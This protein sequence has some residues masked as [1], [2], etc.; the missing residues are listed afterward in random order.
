MASGTRSLDLDVLQVKSLTVKTPQNRAIPS[1]HI[2]ISGGDG[3]TYWN[4]VSSIF[5]VSSF[6]TVVGN[7]GPRFSADLTYNT[8]KISTTGIQGLFE[9][10]I[11]PATSTMML[12]NSLPAS[13]VNLGSVPTVNLIQA[14][15]VPN[16]QQL[17][18]VTGLST[19][20]YF[21]VGD[22]QLSTINTQNAMFFSISSFTSAGYSTI[23]G[24]TFNLRPTIMSTLSTFTGLPSFISSIPFSATWNWGPQLPMSTVDSPPV[25][26]SL[27]FSTMAFRGNSFLPFT[28]STT[29]LF[30]EVKP[31]YFFSSFVLQ[32]DFNLIKPIST[33]L[34][35]GNLQFGESLV[36][37]YITSQVQNTV[38]PAWQGSN[39]FTDSLML[40][41]NSSNFSTACGSNLPITVCHYIPGGVNNGTRSGFDT[42]ASGTAFT[43][44]T[45]KNAGLYVHL[46]N[47]APSTLSV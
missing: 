20:K 4:S 2:L 13:V 39:Y 47:T 42:A 37:R 9:S 19:L 12:S 1:T 22:I 43:N 28:T 29:K 5:P 34:Q 26:G 10:Y 30:V 6:K 16:P 8:L 46:Y 41:L 25:N 35:A 23:S 45:S 38:Q 44:D 31:T 27:F 24:E 11:D 7:S 14:T 40:Q 33:F 3:S 32:S 21:G 17:L 18:P 15:T 36:T